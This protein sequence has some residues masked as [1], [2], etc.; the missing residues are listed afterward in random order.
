MCKARHISKKKL[1]EKQMKTAT[2]STSTA[3][4]VANSAS[5]SFHRNAHLIPNRTAFARAHQGANNYLTN[6]GLEK[7][8]SKLHYLFCFFSMVLVM[9]FVIL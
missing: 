4:A 2:F 8:V 9:L 7:K 5:N 6:P 1:W 3:T